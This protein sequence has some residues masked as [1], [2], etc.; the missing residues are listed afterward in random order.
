MNWRKSMGLWT[1]TLLCGYG[2]VILLNLI[3]SFSFTTLLNLIICLAIIMLP[4]ALFLFIGR[5]MPKKIFNENK[6]MLKI[7]VVKQKICKIT[8]VKVWK[9][10]IP[11]G[12]RVAGFRMNKLEKP[13]DPKYL[14][15]FVFESCFADWLHTTLFFWSFIS[16]FIILFINSSLVLPM[17]LP[18]AI[19]F[20]YQNITSSII[21]WYMRPRLIKLKNITEKRNSQ[22]ELVEKTQ[23]N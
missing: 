22:I 18:F 11:V 5:I 2:L 1:M 6:R 19:L 21:Q 14:G 12:G 7:G 16:I 17:A 10:K 4:A 9:D 20:A 3:F 23:N 8:N 13:N 15:R